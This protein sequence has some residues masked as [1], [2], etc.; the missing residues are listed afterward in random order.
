MIR[1][2]V[3]VYIYIYWCIDG[4]YR[5]YVARF[6]NG[7]ETTFRQGTLYI[8]IDVFLQT[9]GG[10]FASQGLRSVSLL[11]PSPLMLLTTIP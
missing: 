9:G 1:N 4:K 10:I 8:Y 11:S 6:R 3:C 5:I 7:G 2:I